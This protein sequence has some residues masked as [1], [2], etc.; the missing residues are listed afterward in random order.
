MGK[1]NFEEQ[2][3]GVEE[4]SK[5][6]KKSSQNL[7]ETLDQ[8]LNE[9]AEAV[10]NGFPKT[11]RDLM[12]LPYDDKLAFVSVIANP[13]A[14]KKLAKKL[15]KLMRKAGKLSRKTLLRIGLKDVQ[16]RLRKG[17]LLLFSNVFS[18]TR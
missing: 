13:M 8:T 15:F 18:L 14:N 12:D 9:D 1:R 6:H 17:K 11:R 10:P 5:K 3:N 2:Q 4:S 7:D 16:L